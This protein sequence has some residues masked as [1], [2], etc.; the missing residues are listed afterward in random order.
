MLV[1]DG[2]HK[3]FIDIELRIAHGRLL[4]NAQC[5]ARLVIGQQLGRGLLCVLTDLRE[6]AKPQ[7]GHFLLGD[8]AGLELWQFHEHEAQSVDGA[9]GVLHVD[10]GIVVVELLRVRLE[11]G[12]IDQVQRE[13][14]LYLAVVLAY[15]SLLDHRL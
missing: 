2:H 5:L 13:H 6:E 10:H 4:D 11:T 12:V 9:L 7:H 3:L 14:R 8:T 1:D 15:A